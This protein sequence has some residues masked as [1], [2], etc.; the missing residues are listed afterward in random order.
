V[1]RRPS[2]PAREDE[3]SVSATRHEASGINAKGKAKVGRP[4]R[5]L[6]K[7]TPAVE[8]RL[9]A[10]SEK[11]KEDEDQARERNRKAFLS[12]IEVK[13]LDAV[14][15]GLWKA[16]LPKLR[17]RLDVVSWDTGGSGSHAGRDGF[18]PGGQRPVD[19]GS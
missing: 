3:N 5:S 6:D 19:P 2:G 17:K 18:Q 9:R 7:K 10:L 4:S 12:L 13:E 11:K 8:E 15:A 14:P 1:S 16:V